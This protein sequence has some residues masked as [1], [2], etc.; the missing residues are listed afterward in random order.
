MQWIVV[1]WPPEHCAVAAFDDHLIGIQL[2]HSL[3]DA[4]ALFF[5]LQ[6]IGKIQSEIFTKRWV[7]N[8]LPET[9]NSLRQR[10]DTTTCEFLLRLLRQ[11]FVFAFYSYFSSLFVF[12]NSPVNA[13]Y[14]TATTHM[15]KRKTF[16]AIAQSRDQVKSEW[17]DRQ[18]YYSR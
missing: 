11:G 7:I 2:N 12:I 4:F 8:L 6:F 1:T 18:Q 5:P 3:R 16:F 15:P 9:Y 10:C 14:S 17:T 13:I